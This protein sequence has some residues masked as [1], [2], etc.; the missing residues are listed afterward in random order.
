MIIWFLSKIKHSSLN[1]FRNSDFSFSK[2][3]N[4]ITDN[5]TSDNIQLVLDT[6]TR[7]LINETTSDDVN[8]DKFIN[9][10]KLYIFC[11]SFDYAHIINSLI[12]TFCMAELTFVWITFFNFS[13]LKNRFIVHALIWYCQV[14]FYV[15]YWWFIDSFRFRWVFVSIDIFINEYSWVF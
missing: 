1:H 15:F 12:V 9:L 7:N 8:S 4:V 13:F 10:F 2:S 11:F 14:T 6:D 5:L 3:N